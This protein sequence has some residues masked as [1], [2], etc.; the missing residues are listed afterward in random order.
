M[1]SMFFKENVFEI[2]DYIEDGIHIID[3]SGKIIYYNIAAQKLDDIDREKAIGRHVLE[4]YP[5]LSYDTSTLLMVIEEGSYIL[6]KEQT[7][8]NYKGKKITT[9]NSTIPI[10]SNNKIIGALE[11]S[12]DITKVRELSE[13][14]VDLQKVL[15]HD[16]K[17][18][19]FT[20]KVENSYTFADIIGVSDKILKLKSLALRC[21]QTHS[22]V[23]VYGETG[24]GKELFVQAIHNAS[25]RKNKPFIAQNC[26]ALPHNLLEGIL[27]GTV[28]GGF[29]GAE[30]RPGLFELANNGTLFLDEIN[31]M[32][33][34]LQ[35]KLLRVIQDGTIRRLGSVKTKKVDVRIIAATN[36]SFEEAIKSELIR[37]DLYYRLS[38]IN[39][40]IPPLRER[41]EEIKVLTDYFIDK[42]NKM[43]RKNVLGVTKE[44]L[45]VFYNHDWPGNVRELQ[46]VLEGIISISDEDIIEIEHLPYNFKNINII[47]EKFE[48]KSLNTALE[49]LELDIIKK[50]LIETDYNITK[51][52]EMI[53]IP[54]QTLQYKIKKYKLKQCLKLGT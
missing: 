10:K 2:L 12:R 47:E 7:F 23:L 53:D 43:F 16:E 19:D 11:I 26:A 44:V 35:A 28:K 27:F 18:E 30:D 25:P 17:I 52:A 31:S 54:R 38:V 6:N 36:I 41:K 34:E 1:N 15:Y 22:P 48:T 46:H 33:L 14:I 51:T 9:I 49:K 42:Y 3:K 50:A 45:E 4:I 21:S 8:I 20:N 39:L 32:P 24:T 37:K 40:I 29:T 5:S 13:K